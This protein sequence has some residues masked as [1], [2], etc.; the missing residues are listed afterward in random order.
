MPLPSPDNYDDWRDFANALLQALG[1]AQ[2][3]DSL[4]GS[5]DGS[6]VTGTVPASSLPA[7][8][9]S[10][11]P[12]YW[13]FPDQQLFLA[14]DF[15][16]PPPVISPFAIDTQSLA[17]A[18]VE[19][20]TLADNSVSEAKIIDLAVSNAKIA[21]ATILS[22]KIGDAQIVEAKIGNLAVSSAKIM[23][24]AVGTA[25]IADAAITT[26]KIGSAQ[27][28]T[29]QIGTAVITQA[30]MADASIG[31]AQI[32][33]AS[34]ATADIGS[35]QIT[36]AL[37]GLAQI[38]AA[39]IA[40]LAVG[41]A[42]I[43]DAA[44]VNAKIADAT[45]QSAK[46]ANLVFDKLTAGTLNAVVDMGTG[47]IRFSIGGNRLSLG[48]GFGTSN[49]FFM[50]FGPD[51]VET[52]M[53]EAA[54]IFYLKTNGDAYFGGTLLAGTLTN[55]RTT[56]DI[57]PT[58]QVAIGPF[59]TNGNDRTVTLSYSYFSVRDQT[60]ACPAPTT[61]TAQVK[62]YTGLLGDTTTLL[63]TLNVSGTNTCEGG[64][65]SDPGTFETSMGDSVTITDTDH[66]LT[67][68]AYWAE[69]TARA[70]IG[71]GTVTQRV[72]IISVEQ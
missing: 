10:I 44:I 62:L 8:D 27:V 40:N 61:P 57:S 31:S 72:S 45:I 32:I 18:S 6:Q 22:A 25:Q 42:A 28:G 26:V 35:A 67:D 63:A 19:L 64:T 53:S 54:A 68:K 39:L 34:I 11:A 41:T 5:I 15:T 46:I 16:V 37:I 51:M 33:N 66:T 60:T 14:G 23:L 36:T 65:V 21:N 55:Q 70:N 50:W 43:A 7:P 47:L 13:S 56:S 52:A 4:S 24:L 30:L 3:A 20:G 29:A 48:K 71:G 2:E 12:V 38:T 59:G 9:P 1:S 17:L 49:Q 58:A 69:I